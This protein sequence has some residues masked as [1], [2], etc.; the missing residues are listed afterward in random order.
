MARATAVL[1][2]ERAESLFSISSG[3]EANA[4][5]YRETR[6]D[7]SRASS[8][9]LAKCSP[10]VRAMAEANGI[11]NDYDVS[12]KLQVYEEIMEDAGCTSGLCAYNVKRLM[13]EVRGKTVLDLPCGIGLYVR[14]LHELGA[15]KVIASDIVSRQIEVSKEKDKEAAIP[16]G[17]VEYHQHDAAIPEQLSTELAD[18]CLCVHLLCYAETEDQLRGMVRTILANLKPGGCCFI[19]TCFLRGSATDEQTVRKELEKY[20]EE[21]VHLDPPSSERLK[22]RHY[23]S[24]VRGFHF[25]R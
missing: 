17:F 23:H 20:E 9:L 25:N 2:W 19:A 11:P 14:M 15:A 5:V 21:M 18:V 16:E 24:I 6:H 12:E 3:D 22:P 13:P 7:T 1:V 8:S 10:V 4:I